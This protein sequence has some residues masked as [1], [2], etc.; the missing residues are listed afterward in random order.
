MRVARLGAMD[1]PTALSFLLIAAFVYPAVPV[2]GSGGG[3]GMTVS[4]RN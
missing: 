3:V 2:P 1:L 4:A